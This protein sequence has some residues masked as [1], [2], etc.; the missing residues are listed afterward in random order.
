MLKPGRRGVRPAAAQRF[1]GA[2]HRR[3]ASRTCPRTGRPRAPVEVAAAALLLTALSCTMDPGVP[4]EARVRVDVPSSASG[5]HVWLVTSTEFQYDPGAQS[6]VHLLSADTTGATV[7][8]DRDLE[9]GSHAG[10][11]KLYV[12]VRGVDG[13]SLSTRLRV[14]IQNRPWYDETLDLSEWYHRFVFVRSG[15]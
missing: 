1:P 9:I 5:S 7:P 15:G 10:E 2:P 13:E 6:P 12:E 8:F 11:R 4:A 14:T 3:R